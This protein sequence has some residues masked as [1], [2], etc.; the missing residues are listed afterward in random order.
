MNGFSN[1]MGIDVSKD[2]IDVFCTKTSSRFTVPNNDS[3]MAKVF[4]KVDPGCTLAVLES[5][6]GYEK[7]CVK[8]LAAMNIATHRANN[9]QAKAFKESEG[10]NDKSDPI[11]A[12][13]LA[14]YGRQK[15]FD[16]CEQEKSPTPSGQ[17]KFRKM[18][19]KFR[20]HE[21]ASEMQDEIRQFAFRIQSLKEMRVKEK[22]RLQSPG[23]DRMTESCRKMIE[24]LDEEID[25]LE[26]QT[27]E[28]IKS[29]E[30]LIPGT[31]EQQ[32]LPRI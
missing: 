14:L 8:T 13:H 26:R 7:L 5:T 16:L 21:A 3:A 18:K 29:D 30:E 20:I 32:Y 12:E 9:N 28:L 2:K 22:N 31:R 27:L 6:G 15:H 11:D 10:I 17:K 19:R 4:R 24:V 23:Y 25:L 1:F